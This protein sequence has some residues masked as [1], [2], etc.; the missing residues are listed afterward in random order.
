MFSLKKLPYLS[1]R[2]CGVSKW[3]IVTKGVSPA[4]DRWTFV[5]H[6]FSPSLEMR[7]NGFKV[8]SKM[9]T[10]K[11]I[12]SSYDLVDEAVV[13][14][15]P[16]FVHS[17]AYGSVW[18]K[19]SSKAKLCWIS[20]T[21]HGKFNCFTLNRFMNGTMRIYVCSNIT[22]LVG[23]YSMQWRTGKCPCSYRLWGSDPPTVQKL[24]WAQFEK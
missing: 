2:A 16:C 15:D 3:K 12:T 9:I 20:Q 21:V 1:S 5:R 13:E 18:R 17:S 19:Q 4:M 22:Y 7:L 6:S 14:I 10:E 11:S 23:S 8:L 24:P